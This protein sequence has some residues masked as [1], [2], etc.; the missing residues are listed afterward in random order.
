ML[1]HRSGL[2]RYDSM[3]FL[4]KF[5]MEDLVRR[6]RYL[7]PSRTFRDVW[8]YNNLMYVAAGFTGAKLAGTTYEDLV[9]R[10]VFQPLGMRN[11][12]M[13]VKESQKSPDFA[14]PHLLNDGIA[15]EAPFYDYQEFGIGPNG[16]VNSNVDDMLRYLQFHLA[17]D[18]RVLAAEQLRELHKPVIATRQGDASYSLGWQVDYR[19]GQRRMS[20]GG[21]IM[22]FTAHVAMFPEKQIGIVVLNNLGSRLPAAAAEELT[23]RLLGVKGPDRLEELRCRGVT[24]KPEAAQPVPNT[25]PSLR[26]A[27]YAGNYYHPAYGDVRIQAGGARLT[28]VFNAA[29]VEFRHHHFDTFSTS[30]GMARFVLDEKGKPSSV[31]LPVEPAMPPLEFRRQ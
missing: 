6:L 14:M 7:P 23:D 19:G 3:R 15:T 4:V 5:P 16:A 28:A 26:L 24:A 17:G 9:M 12:T 22:G 13:A 31:Y 8:Q 25:K 18:E 1:T 27:D 30:L 10:R 20:H 21:A 2:P 29:T 11:S